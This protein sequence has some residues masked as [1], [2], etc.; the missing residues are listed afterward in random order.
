[1]DQFKG[2]TSPDAAKSGE[3]ILCAAFALTSREAE[4]LV[5]IAHGKSNREISEILLISLRT[6]NKHLERIFAK[7]GVENRA[8]AASMAL[9]A[10][11]D[12]T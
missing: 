3:E 1:M 4:V 12:R 7:L 8:S 6:V 5:W 10:L 2:G 11:I 9:R